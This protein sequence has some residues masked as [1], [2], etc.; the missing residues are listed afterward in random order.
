MA[1]E[2][3]AP[4]TPQESVA[5][6]TQEP[7]QETQEV[8]AQESTPPPETPDE[9]VEIPPERVVP[10]ADGYTLPEGLDPVIGQ[11]ANEHGFTQEQLDSTLEYFGNVIQNSE[12]SKVEALRTLG[13]AHLKNWGDQAQHNLSLAKRA[14]AQNDPEGSLAKA[15]NESGYGNHPAVLDFLYNLGRSMQEGG[16]LRGSVNRPPGQKTLAQTMYGDNHPSK[17]N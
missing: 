6:T 10:A 9:S 12:K 1:E 4:D 13:E 7:V 17:E 5:E 2:T 8:S 14:L 11:F 15:L 3:T 16:F